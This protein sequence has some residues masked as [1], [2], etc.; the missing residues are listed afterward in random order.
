M[1]R[2]PLPLHQAGGCRLTSASES[3]SIEHLGAEN[4]R[5]TCQLVVPRARDEVFLFFADAL[6]LEALTPP[7]LRFRVETAPPIIMTRGARIDY[8]L[9]IHGVPLRWTSAI[10]AWEPP[11]GFSDRQVRGPYR[12]WIH[13]HTFEPAGGGT[14][15]GDR[16]DFAARGGR[17]VGRL[18][19]R[20]LKKIFDYRR[21]R[22]VELFG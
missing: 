22:L 1:A 6:N 12:R 9:R 20:D 21:A 13:E 17:L 4:Y 16:V 15:V 2:L 19:A 11:Q 14:L 8:R 3:V 10:D 18:V 5:L 7:W